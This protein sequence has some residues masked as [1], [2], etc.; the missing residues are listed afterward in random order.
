MKRKNTTTKPRDTFFGTLTHFEYLYWKHEE[1][2]LLSYL[3]LVAGHAAH[4]LHWG[5]H[6]Q[7][8]D[9]F[10]HLNHLDV[11]QSVAQ[12]AILVNTCTIK[13]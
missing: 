5:Q 12:G 10:A 7:E 3:L 1:V 9:V 11:V 2:R 4:V 13:S 8:R 6:Q